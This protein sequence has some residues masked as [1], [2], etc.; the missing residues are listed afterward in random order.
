MMS[1]LHRVRPSCLWLMSLM[2][3]FALTSCTRP[4]GRHSLGGGPLTAEQQAEAAQLF[5]Q[6]Q[7]LT[8]SGDFVSAKAVADELLEG[9]PGSR[10]EA[11]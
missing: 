3:L 11:K 1:T 2:L 10:Q 4:P 9:F 5:A 7:E 8:K 6:L